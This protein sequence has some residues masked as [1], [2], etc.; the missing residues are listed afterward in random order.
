M[1]AYQAVHAL[2]VV[3]HFY[4]IDPALLFSFPVVNGS[5]DYTGGALTALVFFG[6]FGALSVGLVWWAIPK[7]RVRNRKLAIA[8]CVLTVLSFPVGTLV[9]ILMAAVLLAEARKEETTLPRASS[10]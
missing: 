1:L 3:I 7:L 4:R 10:S 2:G 8:V 9:A 5:V 6:I